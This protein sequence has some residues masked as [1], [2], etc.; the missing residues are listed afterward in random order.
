MMSVN[1]S[2]RVY[3]GSPGIPCGS[4]PTDTVVQAA[5]GLNHAFLCL[6]LGAELTAAD[7]CAIIRNCKCNQE[8]G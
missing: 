8:A 4:T 3:R 5:G 2:H 1:L 7:A 6:F